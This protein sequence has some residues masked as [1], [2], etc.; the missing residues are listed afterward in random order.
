MVLLHLLNLS[1]T[2][3]SRSFFSSD[4]FLDSTK[5][6]F[7]RYTQSS[8]NVAYHSF[9]LVSRTST[10]KLDIVYLLAEHCVLALLLC[11]RFNITLDMQRV[12]LV[13]QKDTHR[14]ETKTHAIKK[15]KQ[16]ME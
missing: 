11:L 14:V 2:F 4:M 1:V 5:Y 10:Y 8:P 13:N 15:L 6:L 3:F 12:R 16:K 7:N 9:A